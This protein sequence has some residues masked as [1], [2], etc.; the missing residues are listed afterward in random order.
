[1][2]EADASSEWLGW[3]GSDRRFVGQASEWNSLI[4]ALEVR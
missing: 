3:V 4:V 2:D 1:M